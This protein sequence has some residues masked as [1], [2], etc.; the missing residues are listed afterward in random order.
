MGSGVKY[1]LIELL[2]TPICSNAINLYCMGDLYRLLKIA[3]IIENVR[4]VQISNIIKD[5]LGSDL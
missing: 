4:A 5:T 3:L 2:Q 1:K